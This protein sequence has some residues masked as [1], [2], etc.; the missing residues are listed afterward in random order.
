MVEIVCYDGGVEVSPLMTCRLGT[1]SMA[2]RARRH[3]GSFIIGPWTRSD[4]EQHGICF[5]WRIP[6]GKGG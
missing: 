6:L 1:A 4:G 2:G 5:T 3:G